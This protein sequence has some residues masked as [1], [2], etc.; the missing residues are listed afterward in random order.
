M[1]AGSRGEEA[2]ANPVAAALLMAMERHG[3]PADVLSD[4]IN[5]HRF[6]LY[7]DPMASIA[8]LDAAMEKGVNYPRGPLKWANEIGIEKIRSVLK[9]IAVFYGEDRYR[10]S[11][12]LNEMVLGG[13]IFV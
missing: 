7:D 13:K 11:P 1:V 6:D 10:V 8:D 2:A 3:L 5:A 9:N 12:L 4:L